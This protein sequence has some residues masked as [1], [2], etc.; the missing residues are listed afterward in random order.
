MK[1]RSPWSVVL[2]LCMAA[3]ITGCMTLATTHFGPEPLIDCTS[4]PWSH[5]R[6]YSGTHEIFLSSQPRKPQRKP[7]S[8]ESRDM[9]QM[10]VMFFPM[11]VMDV[12]LSLAADTLIL[13]LTI[14]LQNKYGDIQ[15]VCPHTPPE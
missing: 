15:V 14:Y 6:I 9:A 7:T 13:P 8:E 3:T 5:P 12:P 1:K 2:A 4:D 10:I 11:I